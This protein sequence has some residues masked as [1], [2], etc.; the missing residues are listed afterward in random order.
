MKLQILI[1]HYKEPESTIKN[2]LDSIELQQNVNR[3]DFSVIIVNDGDDLLLTKEFLNRYNFQLEY[4]VHK[5]SGV[6]STRNALLQLAKAEYVMFCD[7]DDMFFD[8]R[9]LGLLINTLQENPCDMLVSGFIEEIKDVDNKIVYVNHAEEVHPFIHGKIFRRD[10]LIQNKIYFYE[11][12]QFNEDVVFSYLAHSLTTRTN[13]NPEKFYL[14]RWNQGSTTRQEKDWP[15]CTAVQRMEALDLLVDELNQRQLIEARNYF[16]LL[17]IYETYYNM[18]EPGW[19][20]PIIQQK[21]KKKTELEMKRFWLKW[22]DIYEKEI[23]LEYKNN[24]AF[25]S[26]KKALEKVDIVFENI[27]FNNWLQ[28]IESLK[29]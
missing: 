16:I 11:E 21:Y 18:A 13:F 23:S 25:L 5:H 10:F 22:K 26:K 2:L 17:T 1:P 4:I 27:T 9:G 19:Q 12:L 15:Y 6:S 28:Y 7:A 8:I 14:W 20:N 3:D 29:E 24:I